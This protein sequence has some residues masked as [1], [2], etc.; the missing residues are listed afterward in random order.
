MERMLIC[1]TL[2][3]VLRWLGEAC[4]D[5]V[6]AYSIWRIVGDYIRSTQQGN[7]E[8]KVGMQC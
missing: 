1:G 4:E 6:V 3:T 8:E 5:L 7:E 2:K